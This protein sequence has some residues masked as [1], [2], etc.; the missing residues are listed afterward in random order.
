VNPDCWRLGQNAWMILSIACFEV[1]VWVKFSPG[2]IFTSPPPLEVALP[3][4]AFLVMFSIWMAIFF[5]QPR[6]RTPV[7]KGR[8]SLFASPSKKQDPS[9]VTSWGKLDVLFWISF[10]PLLALSMQWAY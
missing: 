6:P 10:T 3:I 4:L 8:R 9:D 2:V 7:A 1:L 5:S